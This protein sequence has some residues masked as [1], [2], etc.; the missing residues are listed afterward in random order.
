MDITAI[1]IVQNFIQ[2]SSLK[3]KSIHR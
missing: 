3:V 2:Y 1:N